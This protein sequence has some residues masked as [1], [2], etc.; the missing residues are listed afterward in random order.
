MTEELPP[1]SR[2]LHHWFMVYVRWYLRRHFHALRVARGDGAGS[3]PPALADRPVVIYTNHPGWWDPLIFLT[4]AQT[5]YPERMNYGPIDAGA[6]GKYKFL[7]RIG[8]VGIEAGTRQGA[9]RFLR[10]ARAAG[11]RSDVI[12]WITAQ[13]AFT[14]PRRR[15]LEIRPGVGHAVAGLS[16]GLIVPLA[17]EYPFW[18]ERLPEAL[19]AFGE[20]L[21]VDAAPDRDAH[22]WTALLASRLEATQDRLAAAALSRDPSSFHTLLAGRVGVGGIYDCVRRAGAWWRGETFDAS[23]GGAE[24]GAQG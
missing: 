16:R 24:P 3:Q 19:V 22:A 4:V 21:E 12:F 20:P 17:V 9:A 5:L 10:T 2:S 7:E 14:D 15:P 11:R 6:L 13:G 1:F 8:F 18:N 23:H